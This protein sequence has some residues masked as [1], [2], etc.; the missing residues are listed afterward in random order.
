VS[1]RLM[2]NVRSKS[3]VVFLEVTRAQRFHELYF[4]L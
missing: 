2:V 4:D 1:W 3:G